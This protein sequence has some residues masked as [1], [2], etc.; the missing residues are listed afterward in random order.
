MAGRRDDSGRGRGRVSFAG[1]ISVVLAAAALFA[2]CPRTAAAAPFD[3]RLGAD[4]LYARV[5]HGG[6]VDYAAIER[7][8]APLDR[9][10]RAMAAAP[11]E[12]L[13]AI[14]APR[15]LAYYLNAYN[16]ATLD[17]IL[18]FRKERGGRL[19]SIQEIPGAWSR[20]RWRIGGV[21][22]TLD[23]LEHR[24]IRLEF[25][26]PR[27]HMALVC[28][29]RSCPPLPAKAFAGADLEA[30]L[31]N[32]ARAFVNDE[33]RNRITPGDG[34][35]RISKIFEWYGGDFVGH[36]RDEALDYLYGEKN[37]AVLAFAS[38]YL[39]EAAVKAL[40]LKEA[41]VE[42]L[43]YDWNLNAAPAATP[44]AAVKKR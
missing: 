20:Y 39:P 17:L 1:A 22:R 14:A 11:P 40:R 29:S 23:D 26:E 25:S 6:L 18:R 35:V 5:V 9:A 24:V 19:G 28:A 36:Y 32:A 31:E 44:T 12:T 43:P 34:R 38:R 21:E 15:R 42:F 7:D 37:G 27:V 8:R 30:A 41:A 16:L 2:G 10:L 33:T 13:A 3:E 4:S